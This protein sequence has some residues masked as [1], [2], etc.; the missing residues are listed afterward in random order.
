MIGEIELQFAYV[1]KYNC[2][3]VN[4]QRQ[5]HEMPEYF[6]QINVYLFIFFLKKIYTKY[7][8]TAVVNESPVPRITLIHTCRVNF[9]FSSS[10][11]LYCSNVISNCRVIRGPRDACKTYQHDCSL[12]ELWFRTRSLL[13]FVLFR[14]KKEIY[15]CKKKHNL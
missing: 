8:I 14:E 13:I 1:W 15:L 11:L 2:H 5:G 7:R 3:G 10:I 12:Y 9:F 4:C 6:W